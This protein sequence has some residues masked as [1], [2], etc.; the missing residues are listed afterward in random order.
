[1]PTGKVEFISI[2]TARRGNVQAVQ[3]VTAN[4][5]NGLNGDHYSSKSGKRQ[6]TLIQ[7]EHL[8]VV[9]SLLKKAQIDPILTR[10]NIVVSGIN[11]LALDGKQFQIGQAILE[12]TGPCEPCERMEENL[13]PGGLDAMQG[14]GGITAKVIRG[15]I[16][17][18]GD[19]VAPLPK[20]T[21]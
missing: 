5:E 16:I 13:G 6:V 8:P 12:M 1:M 2:R 21:P 3:S 19:D 4:E 11:L 7:A 14:H 20:T 15:G 17:N 9:A 18:I 10:R